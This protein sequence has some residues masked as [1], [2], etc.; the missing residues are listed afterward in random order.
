MRVPGGSTTASRVASAPRSGSPADLSTTESLSPRCRSR[1]WQWP[2]RRRWREGN[3]RTETP[4]HPASVSRCRM[5]G[6]EARHSPPPRGRGGADQ[7]DGRP[8]PINRHGSYL[9]P[10]RGADSRGIGQRTVAPQSRHKPV[11]LVVV[12]AQRPDVSGKS[13]EDVRPATQSPPLGINA[14]PSVV[15]GR[16]PPRY[17]ATATRSPEG[18]TANTSASPTWW[19]RMGEPPGV[20]AKS[21]ERVLPA[22][23]TVPACSTASRRTDPSSG[24]CQPASQ[25]PHRRKSSA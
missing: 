4:R 7:Q 11:D 22:I 3:T 8:V 21:G 5:S 6:R 1:P 9:V 18:G 15:S 10:L 16:D 19:S 14:I 23:Q 17:V 12:P 24:R 13:G 2:L 25:T 20:T